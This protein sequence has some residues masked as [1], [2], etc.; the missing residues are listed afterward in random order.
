MSDISTY[1]RSNDTSIGD[2]IN[3]EWILHCAKSCDR[4]ILLVTRDSDYGIIY[5]REIIL[6]DWL[7]QEFRQRISQKRKLIITDKLT[8]AFKRVNIPVTRQEEEEE[9]SLI[10]GREDYNSHD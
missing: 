4:H 1:L 10:E 5:N 6:N 7:A 9:A 8:Q 2:A 3:W